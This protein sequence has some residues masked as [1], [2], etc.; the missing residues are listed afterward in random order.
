MD[1]HGRRPTPGQLLVA[2]ALVVMT[3][4]S[5]VAAS[6]IG[7][8]DIQN[9]AVT[10]KKIAA[11]AVGNK[12]LKD[13]AV[14]GAKITD[15]A[16][17]GAKIADGAV[18]GS[19]LAAGTI[20]GSQVANDSLNDTKLSDYEVIGNSPVRVVATEAANLAA[21]QAAAPENPLIAKGPITIYAKC[22]RDTTAGHLQG[23][24]FV[25]TS[26]DGALMQGD[27]TIP[28][29]S[30]IL[31]NTNT[32]ENSRTLEVGETDAANAANISDDEGMVIGPDG[33]TLRT[34]TSIA[35]KQGTL[36]NGQGPFG[37]GNV[38]LFAGG[39]LG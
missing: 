16:V 25:R 6:K 22:F 32:P 12:K 28:I 17:N 36:P 34:L 11:N 1:S 26:A 19:D 10:G 3:A 23:S 35:V 4:G 7:T 29:N 33:T 2:I 21:A 24:I 38:C 8:V 9:G 30:E 27:D 31:L 5:A 13:G 18:T 37:N 20:T 39:I 14:N 15:G